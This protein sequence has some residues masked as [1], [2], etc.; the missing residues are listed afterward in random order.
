MHSLYILFCLL[1]VAPSVNASDTPEQFCQRFF[2]SLDSEGY[3]AAP[4]FFHSE[5][6]ARFKAM[7]IPIFEPD[8]KKNLHNFFG[9]EATI[10]TVNAMPPEKFM[11]AFMSIIDQQ[12]EKLGKRSSSTKLIGSVKEGDLAHVVVRVHTDNKEQV[13]VFSLR[14]DGSSWKLLLNRSLEGIAQTFLTQARQHQQ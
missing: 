8:D 14:P 6:I 7:L 2:S 3:I 5:E 10:E 9:P 11:Y 4:K 1:V 12:I 13:Q